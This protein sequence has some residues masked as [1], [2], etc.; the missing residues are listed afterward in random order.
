LKRHSSVFNTRSNYFIHRH[1][2]RVTSH[3]LGNRFWSHCRGLG[4]CSWWM[5]TC[6]CTK[7][8]VPGI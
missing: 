3:K 5:E 7:V 1:I 6:W 4:W 8:F 2:E